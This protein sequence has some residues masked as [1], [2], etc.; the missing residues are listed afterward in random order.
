VFVG[1]LPAIACAEVL[2][3]HATLNRGCFYYFERPYLGSPRYTVRTPLV[4]VRAAVRV[5]DTG[6]PAA[7][8]VFV[9]DDPEPLSHE[10]ADCSTAS[11]WRNSGQSARPFAVCEATG[12]VSLGIS[13]A[14]L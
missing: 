12:T 14:V 6:L 7:K 4:F 5:H 10:R 11:T 8:R 3:E 2:T 9:V 1:C 13:Y